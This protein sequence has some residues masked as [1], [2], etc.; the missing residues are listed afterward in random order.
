A[1]A[2]QLSRLLLGPL[3]QVKAKR[4]LIVPD[5]SLQYLPFA[6]LPFPGGNGREKPLIS[7]QEIL[8]L[9]SA[10]VLAGLRRASAHRSP[11]TSAAAIFADP[12]F[13]PDAPR[14]SGVR[15]PLKTTSQDR[16]AALTRAIQDLGK[17]T[18]IPRLPASRNEANAIAT[19]L[20]AHDPKGV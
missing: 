13:E 12:V 7:A 2:R 3:T 4:I 15:T 16:P 20:R 19:V 5:G 9:P 8:T 17:G 1:S 6:A 14:V 10:S 18:Y 11:P